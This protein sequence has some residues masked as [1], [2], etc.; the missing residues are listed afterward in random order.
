MI[1][2]PLL[3]VIEYNMIGKKRKDL[4]LERI[5]VPILWSIKEGDSV[6]LLLTRG[7]G[8][9]VWS[10]LDVITDFEVSAGPC[11][12]LP[13]YTNHTILCASSV[14]FFVET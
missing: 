2:F 9:A 12:L 14:P 11:S 10:S 1:M 7:E 6:T 13:G 5:L 4:Y 3:D 8:D